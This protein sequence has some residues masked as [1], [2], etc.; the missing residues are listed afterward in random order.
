ME[1]RHADRLREK[2]GTALVDTPVIIL[3]IPDTYPFLDAGLQQ[4]LRDKLRESA[5]VVA[6]YGRA[7]SRPWR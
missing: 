4:L 1:R 5:A 7:T 6:G 2:F 3:R